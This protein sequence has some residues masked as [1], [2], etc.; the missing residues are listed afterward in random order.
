[1]VTVQ[2][3]ADGLSLCSVTFQ[4]SAAREGSDFGV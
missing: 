1:M 3:G 2:A 4:V